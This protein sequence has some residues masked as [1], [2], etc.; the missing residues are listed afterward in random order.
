MAEERLTAD[1]RSELLKRIKGR[2]RVA[3]SAAKA[4]GH[5]LRAEFEKRIAKTYPKNHAPW[6]EA[7][8]VAEDAVAKANAIVAKH[9][10]ALGVPPSL[11]PALALQW[12][13][14]GENSLQSRRV[15]LRRAATAI[16]AEREA[17]AIHAIQAATLEALEGVG[18][19][20]LTTVAARELLAGLPDAEALLPPVGIEE[21]EDR[22]D[23]P[24]EELKKL[25]VYGLDE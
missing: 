8:Q 2:E 20:R 17:A 25:G 24:A 12:A 19:D 13:C 6:A 18:D 22:A 23:R 10:A 14:R 7:T 16:L 9:C 21:A 1:E 11:A 4:R 15:E 5:A 3:L